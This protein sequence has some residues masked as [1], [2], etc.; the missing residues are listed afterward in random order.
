[1]TLHFYLQPGHFLSSLRVSLTICLLSI[2]THMSDRHLGS[3]YP[4]LSS[5]P[6]LLCLPPNSL[7]HPSKRQ[8]HPSFPQAK[9]LEITIDTLLFLISHRWPGSQSHWRFKE[10]PES[11]PRWPPALL[12]PCSKPPSSLLWTIEIVSSWPPCFSLAPFSPCHSSAH[13]SAVAAHFTL[14]EAQI[15]IMAHSVSYIGLL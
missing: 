6:P 9:S 14:L 5:R 13:Y 15:L 7:P 3:V 1:M 12:L 4:K 2:S 8:L 10:Y 11:T